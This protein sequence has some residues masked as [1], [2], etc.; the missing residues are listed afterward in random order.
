MSDAILIERLHY[1]AG[2]TFEI[3]ELDLHVP[4]GSIYGF[5]GPNGS[6]K[7]TTIRLILGLLR[8]LSGRITVLGDPMPEQHARVLARIG[9]VPEQ[10][11]LDATLTVR[12]LIQFQS[13]FYPRWDRARADELVRRFEL[14]GDQLFG[15][16]SKGQKAKL[17]IL[18]ALSQCGE[19][20]VL[21]EPTDGL[22]PVVRRDILSALLTYVSERRATIFISSHLVHELER[23]CDWVA[24]MDDGRL[25]TEAPM[26]KLKGGTKRLVVMDAPAEIVD[27]PFR[28]LTRESANGAGAGE[29]WVVGDWE[30]A[31]TSYFEGVGAS[32]REVIDLDLEDGF[33]ELLR[34][35]RDVKGGAR[36]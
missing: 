1:R 36:R 14:E 28:V 11:H 20:L 4:A 18:L 22:D 16:L 19:L 32:V 25:I 34:S 35:F 15:R 29:N 9:Y 30:P 21:D 3:R 6:G 5:L 26:E 7:T 24:V 10:P 12:E 13:A 8:P 17:M 27:A 2:K 33:V 23:V 31:M